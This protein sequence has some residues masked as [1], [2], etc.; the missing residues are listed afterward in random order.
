VI[1]VGF[2]GDSGRVPR[3]PASVGRHRVLVTVPSGA[4]TGPLRLVDTRGRR[5]LSPRLRVVSPAALPAP[6]SFAV[7]GSKVRP[8]RAFFDDKP[9]VRLR[10]RFRSYGAL[11]M[12]VKLIRSGSVVKTWL[13]KDRLPYA[14]HR[15][16]W[17]GMLGHG[18]AAPRGRYR[19]KL[20]A[21]G[22][23]AR[24][25]GGLRLADGRFPV[26][27]PH[28][29]GGAVQRFGA[30]RSGG[31]THEGQDVFA[32]CGTPVVAARGGRVQSRGTDPVL[33]G[34]WVVIDGRGTSADHR[35]AHFMRPASV[36]DGER[37]RTGDRIGR[38]GR[39]GNAR[40][41]GCMLHFE[42]WP[43]GWHRRSPADPLSLLRRWDRWP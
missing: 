32:P 21:P 30:P 15:L 40:T 26:R 25:V 38:V 3:A 37:V 27:G 22:N 36:R 9:G 2:R 18:D 14:P 7:I 13:Q 24:L 16:T 19:F 11:D 20:K 5:A 39:T 8:R 31:R 23:R 41:V 33:Y 17:N 29:Y 10:Y 35:Y 43:S 34:N 42:A 12:T 4:R 1:E 6:G 28:D